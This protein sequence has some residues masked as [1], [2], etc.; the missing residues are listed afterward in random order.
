MMA[1]SQT[2]FNLSSTTFPKILQ[3]DSTKYRRRLERLDAKT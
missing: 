3:K 2:T 1:L